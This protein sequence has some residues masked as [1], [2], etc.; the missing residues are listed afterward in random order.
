MGCARSPSGRSPNHLERW[1]RLFAGRCAPFADTGDC[2]LTD[3]GRHLP[4]IGNV[5]LALAFRCVAQ[6]SQD[7][8]RPLQVIAH[9]HQK[10]AL[11]NLLIA[12]SAV[13]AGTAALSTAARPKTRRLQAPPW[14][15]P[16]STNAESATRGPSDTLLDALPNVAAIVWA[17]LGNRR[18]VHRVEHTL[19]RSKF[20][21]ARFTP[22]EMALDR[23]LLRPT[24]RNKKAPTVL[25][26][27][28]S[29]CCT[30]HRFQASAK[31]LD[32]SKNTVFRSVRASPERF[33]DLVDRHALEV[34]QH[35]RGSF[36]RAQ[37]VQGRS[38]A[39]A[40]GCCIDPDPARELTGSVG[41]MSRSVGP[42]S[43]LSS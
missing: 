4:L 12:D 34:P 15:A 18:R 11:A 40:P 21:A 27:Y 9:G 37:L 35:E 28:D 42:R 36:L 1:L 6:F 29:S 13:P 2:H 20:V 19:Q 14:R 5:E 23:R 26:Q 10:D 38:P 43:R 31:L 22:R 33:A 41:R 32:R 30:H 3:P 8:L 24:L 16:R 39:P 7:H 17:A 25:R